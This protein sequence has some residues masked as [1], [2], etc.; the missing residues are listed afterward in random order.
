MGLIYVLV[1]ATL[2]FI[3]IYNKVFDGNK[4]I[5]ELSPIFRNIIED[6]YEFLVRLRYEDEDV[7]LEEMFEKRIRNAV[8]TF[9][10]VSQ[11]LMKRHSVGVLLCEALT[12]RIA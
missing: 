10:I 8:L 12:C 7:D 11:E 6:D 4:F 9:L 5:K 1:T 3:F 2:V